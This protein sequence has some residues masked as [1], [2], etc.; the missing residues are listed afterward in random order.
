MFLTIIYRKESNVLPSPVASP[1]PHVRVMF[2]RELIFV[3]F[4]GWKDSRAKERAVACK[5]YERRQGYTI[6]N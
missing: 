5:G 4:G 2:Y 3:T 1:L 6:E